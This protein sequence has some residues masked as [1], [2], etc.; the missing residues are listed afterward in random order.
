MTPQLHSLRQAGVASL[1][2]WTVFHLYC[3]GHYPAAQSLQNKTF[4]MHT[5]TSKTVKPQRTEGLMGGGDTG[6]ACE[7]EGTAQKKKKSMHAACV[8]WLMLPPLCQIN[9]TGQGREGG[10]EKCERGAGFSPFIKG[11]FILPSFFFSL[12]KGVPTPEWAIHSVIAYHEV[13]ATLSTLEF[14]PLE[15]TFCIKHAVTILLQMSVTNAGSRI[16]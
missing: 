8:N 16:C 3:T 13:K 10:R 15:M 11:P 1:R 4:V 2:G 6:E 9:S 7:V 14:S 5:N 12:C